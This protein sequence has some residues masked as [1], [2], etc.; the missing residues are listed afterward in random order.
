MKNSIKIIGALTAIVFICDLKRR[1]EPPRIFVKDNISGG[2]NAKTVPP[3]GIFISKSQMHNSNLIAHEKVHWKQY[4][5]LGLLGFYSKYLTEF[6]QYGYDN[7]PMEKQA[8]EIES[9]YCKVNYTEC[10]KKGIAKTVSNP[11]F[12]V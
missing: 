4:Q 1:K 6:V 10:V 5:E 11:N 3:I 9:D 2:F 12:R 7:M 8:R